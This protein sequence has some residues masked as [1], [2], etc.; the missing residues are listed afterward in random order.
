MASGDS[1]L[2]FRAT[3][4]EPP[5]ADAAP[6]NSVLS[7]SADEPDNVL[8]ALDF[9]DGATNE[10]AVFSAVMPRQY[11]GGGVTVTLVWFSGAAT[12]GNA[13][14]E[15]AFKSLG[16]SDSVNKVSAA[17]QVTTDTTDGTAKDLTYATIA[18]T[19]GA[20]MDSV[21]VGEMFQLRVNADSADAGHT[22][23]GDA[24]LIMVEIKET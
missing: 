4:N 18:F 2:I 12:T 16:D 13:R 7:A 5:D 3:D 15:V 6:V 14:F 21:A 8:Y 24:R 19:D 9:D 23:V 20:Q 10:F 11:G 22:L 17:A 1:L